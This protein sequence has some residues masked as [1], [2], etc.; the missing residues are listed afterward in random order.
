MEALLSLL[1]HPLIAILLLLGAL[2]FFHEA[3]HFLVG[4]ACGI[5]VEIFSIGFGPVIFGFQRGETHYRLSAIPLGGFVKFYGSL[6]GEDVPDDVVGREFVSASLMKRFLT[7]VAGPVAN[8]LLAFVCYAVMGYSGIEQPPSAVGEVMKGSPAEKGGLQFGDQ[9]LEIDGKPTKTWRD[10][11]EIVYSSPGKPLKFLVDRRGIKNE[12]TVTP[13]VVK[14]PDMIPLA[15]YGRIGISPGKVPSFID[16]RDSQSIAYK[17]GLRSGDKVVRIRVGSQ[18]QNIRYYR[19]LLALL[20][21]AYKNGETEASLKVKRGDGEQWFQWSMSGH[22]IGDLGIHHAQLTVKAITDK[23]IQGVLPGDTILAWN[24]QQ[25]A[26]IFEY[27]EKASD[28]RQPSVQLSVLRN[29]KV[30]PVTVRLKPVEVQKAEGKVTLYILPAK[31]LGQMV[32]PDPVVEEYGLLGAMGYGWSTTLKQTGVIA[33]AVFHL[34]KGDMPLKALGGPISIAKVASDSV[35]LGWMTFFSA[36]ALISINLGLLNLIPIPVLG[37][38][39]L[40]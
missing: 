26:S 39:V 24:G 34:I 13:D 25:I 17:A 23:T 32:Q 5:A 35:K 9:V 28:H 30:V 11:H 21:K 40:G 7:I 12:L 2:V 33:S 20:A 22:S 4:K 31:F 1:S 15:E 37:S 27:S 29:M 19:E 6:P 14:N 3:G 18:E 10:L 8:F 38:A 36:M 16:V